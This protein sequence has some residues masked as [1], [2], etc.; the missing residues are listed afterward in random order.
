MKDAPTRRR[1][2]PLACRLAT[3]AEMPAISALAIRSF[4]QSIAPL[5]DALGVAN[6]LA[7]ASSAAMEGRWG[8]DQFV[9]VSEDAGRALLGMIEV[10]ANRHISMFFV[11]P[12]H[13]RQGVGRTLLTQ[14]IALIRQRNPT[15]EALTVNASPNAVGAYRR[16]GFHYA[17]P[18]QQTDGILYR[19]MV[20]YLTDWPGASA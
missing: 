15:L 11:D 4:Q 20:L 5:Y 9:L 14:A 12:D 7:Y 3:L 8:H 13:F 1:H 19:P 10:R 18:M 17:A 2:T 16:F 6:F